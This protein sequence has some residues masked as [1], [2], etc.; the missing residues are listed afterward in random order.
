MKKLLL[1]LL[2]LCSSAFADTALIIHQGYNGVHT[3]VGSALTSAGHTVTYSTAEVYDLSA[4]DQVWDLRYSSLSTTQA[5]AYDGFVQGGGF[6]YLVTENP[7]CCG[8]R[9]TAVGNMISAMGGGSGLT[10]GGAAGSTSNT[11]SQVNLTYMTDLAGN[12]ITFAAGSAIVNYGNGQWLMKDASGNVAGVMWVGN[13]GNLAEGYTGTVITVADI[14]W[15]DNSYMTAVNATALDDIIDG[16]VAGTVEG[17][18]SESGNSGGPTT[19]TTTGTSLGPTSTQATRRA[20]A[21]TRRDSYYDNGI[22]IDQAGSNNSI[23]ILQDSSDNQI[24]GIDQQRAKMW[25]NN[26]TYDIRQGAP[27]TTGINLIELMVDGDSNNLTLF[28]DRF[29]AGGADSSASGDNILRIDIDGNSNTV[30]TNQRGETNAGGQFGE[31][32]ITGNL[33]DVTMVQRSTLG[34]T[35]FID[36]TG[37][38]NVVDLLQQNTSN[39]VGS[40]KFADIKLTGDGHTVNLTQDGTGGHQAT[41]DLTYGSASSTVNLDQLGSTSQSF[42]LEQTCY[43][44]GGCSTTITQQ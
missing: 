33:N 30:A 25:G 38:S 22:Y 21:I 43:T 37:D 40:T 6:L 24:R 1:L 2:F 28:Q 23:T 4:Y 35:A 11:I 29:D 27:T 42:S 8:T 17:T 41:I 13:A 3:N 15:L 7:G 18:I 5:T 34:E 32:N 19:T 9:N 10:I 44:A 26:N 12:S 39:A 31:I 36:I 14:N 16:I 20:E